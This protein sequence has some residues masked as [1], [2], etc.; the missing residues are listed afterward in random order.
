M[1]ADE[2]MRRQEEMLRKKMR[3]GPK[4]KGLLAGKSAKDVS[5]TEIF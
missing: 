4:K 3:R 1:D 5:F 2:E